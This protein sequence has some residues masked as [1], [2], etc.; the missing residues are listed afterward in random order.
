MKL[1]QVF[2]EPKKAIDFHDLS[3]LTQ[4][5]I[6]ASDELSAMSEEVAKA[7]TIREFS[8]DLRKR[9]LALSTREFLE[10]DSA[11]ASDT[12]GRAS[13]RYGDDLKQLQ[14][15]LYEA[16]STLARHEAARIRWESIR[17]ALSSWKAITGNI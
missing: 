3:S 6:T 1:G 4:Q 13:L 12:K 15:D 2:H 16:E 14:K 8:G 11:A 7:K 5:L 9:A 17:S 10:T